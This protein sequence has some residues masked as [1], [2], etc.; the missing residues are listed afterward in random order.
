MNIGHKAID[1]IPPVRVRGLVLEVTDS[2]GA[3]ELRELSVHYAGG[4]A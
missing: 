3:P 4:F 1:R 2:D